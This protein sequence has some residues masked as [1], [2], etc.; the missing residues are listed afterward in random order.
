MNSNCHTM[1]DEK[2]RDRL[3]IDLMSNL[4]SLVSQTCTSTF[5]SLCSLLRGLTIATRRLEGLP[6]FEVITEDNFIFFSEKQKCT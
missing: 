2:H 6:P 3:L 1:L 4:S 5:F